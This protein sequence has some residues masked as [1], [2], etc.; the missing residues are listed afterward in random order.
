MAGP[1]IGV[2]ERRTI[3]DLGA[4]EGDGQPRFVFCDPCEASEDPRP[5][6]FAARHRAS[7]LK[8]AGRQVAGELTL[9]RV[10]EP[11]Q[12]EGQIGR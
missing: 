2:E 1:S 8:F 10:S 7:E 6:V 9:V 12:Y 3:V 11:W 5:A 4:D